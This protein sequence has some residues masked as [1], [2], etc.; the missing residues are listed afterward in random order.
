M[1]HTTSARN[2]RTNPGCACYVH[3]HVYVNSNT[4]LVSCRVPVAVGWSSW[5]LAT[6]TW[7]AGNR[8]PAA[9]SN[10]GGWTFGSA[11]SGR[12]WGTDGPGSAARRPSRNLRPGPETSTEPGT[13]LWK[14]KIVIHQRYFCTDLTIRRPRTRHKLSLIAV[15]WSSPVL[16]GVQRGGRQNVLRG[17]GVLIDDSRF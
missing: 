14:K 2:Y 5:A 16:S 9:C 17:G 10:R 4:R 7:A 1:P 3:Y 13:W 15:N 12:R 11:G 8:I 6:A